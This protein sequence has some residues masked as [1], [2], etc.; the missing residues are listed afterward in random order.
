MGWRKREDRA[1]PKEEELRNITTFLFTPRCIRGETRWLEVVTIRQQFH[2][3]RLVH[4]RNE[5]GGVYLNVLCS[6]WEDVDFL[7]IGWMKWNRQRKPLN[8]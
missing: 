8:E 6:E 3:S 7:D 1:N 5:Y 2:E 4:C